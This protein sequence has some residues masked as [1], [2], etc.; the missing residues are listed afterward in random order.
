M[1][2]WNLAQIFK[3]INFRENCS[4]SWNYGTPPK[5]FEKK[6]VSL[7]VSNRKY[8]LIEESEAYLSKNREH[9]FFRKLLPAEKKLYFPAY[10]LFSKTEIYYLKQLSRINF[11]RFMPNFK[12]ISAF[13]RVKNEKLTFPWYISGKRLLD[14]KINNR[15]KWNIKIGSL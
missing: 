1:S 5:F 15:E 7:R 2:F 11:Y 13:F 14:C 4:K 6:R 3:R 12:V 8:I 9:I 10:L